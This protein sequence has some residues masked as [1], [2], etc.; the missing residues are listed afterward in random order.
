M[1]K[2]KEDVS[3][4][5]GVLEACMRGFE[6]DS[7]SF[8]NSTAEVE[9]R[10]NSSWSRFFKLWKK[11]SIK[12]L[13]SFPPLAVPKVPKRKSGS[14]REN[15]QLS[16]LYNINSSLVNFS[17]SDLLTATDNFSQGLYHD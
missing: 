1:E 9:S 3:S 13:A 10:S 17:L 4:P 7:F 15:P 5:R 14:T 6:S 2:E 16:H 8:K 12:R 11:Q